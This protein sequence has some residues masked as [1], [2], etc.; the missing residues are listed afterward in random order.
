MVPSSVGFT[1][2]SCLGWLLILRSVPG[3][4]NKAA[5]RI[6][7]TVLMAA[8]LVEAGGAMLSHWVFSSASLQQ[9]GF[10]A[11]AAAAL[12]IL[13][14]YWIEVSS[15]F[16]FSGQ[17]N[18]NQLCLSIWIALALFVCGTLANMLFTFEPYSPGLVTVL[19]VKGISLLYCIIAYM[20]LVFEIGRSARFMA[21]G[22]QS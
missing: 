3:M 6:R 21:Q 17:V 13:R 5:H 1:L 16:N 8:M 2:I 7:V 19:A 12:W 11:L 22:K 20:G 18:W 14:K 15:W 9:L 4:E 10:A